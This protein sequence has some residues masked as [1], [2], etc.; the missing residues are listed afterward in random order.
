MRLVCK[1]I[2][3]LLPLPKLDLEVYRITY[4]TLTNWVFHVPD[5]PIRNLRTKFLIKHGVG[6]CKGFP[7]LDISD[8]ANIN[9]VVMLQTLCENMAG[10]T[11]REVK[12]SILD[13]KY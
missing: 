7:Y 6:V 11:T 9:V 3:N 8:P 2:S 10:L 12:K 4:D 13:R 1:G 5:G